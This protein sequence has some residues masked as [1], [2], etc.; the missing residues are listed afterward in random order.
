MLALLAL[1]LASCAALN[2]LLPC[3]EKDSSAKWGNR[4]TKP[5]SEGLTSE[6]HRGLHGPFCPVWTV[7]ALPQ[8]KAVRAERTMQRG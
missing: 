5:C 8:G 2:K 1:P 7:V 4:G 6:T 3:P